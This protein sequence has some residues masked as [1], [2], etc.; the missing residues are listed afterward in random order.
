MRVTWQL[1]LSLLFGILGGIIG[2]TVSL[3]LQSDDW[4][5]IISAKVVR[6][7]RFELLDSED[8]RPVAYW[9]HD[10]ANQ[11]ILIA[12]VDRIGRPR[13]G[14]GVQLNQSEDGKTAIYSPFLTFT[15]SD[16]A[17]RLQAR[18]DLANNPVLM[19]GDSGTEDRMVLGHFARGDVA[20][21]SRDSWDKWSLVFRDPSR[22][23][24]D[25][26]DIGATTPL[27]SKRRTGYLILRNSQG[28]RLLSEPK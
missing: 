13:A 27:N 2:V 24:R 11:R 28:Q 10:W 14:F 23:W 20:G 1:L 8:S 21:S 15:D 18:L 6:A 3:R 26:V 19:M 7:T 4:S 9:S 25:Y 22:G 5:R 17:T 16:N 12:F